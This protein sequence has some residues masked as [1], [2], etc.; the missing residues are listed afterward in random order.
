MTV[1][2]TSFDYTKD[3]ARALHGLRSKYEERRDH[4]FRLKNHV[5]RMLTR[6]LADEGL[7]EQVHVSGRVKEL[8][9]FRRKVKDRYDRLTHGILKRERVRKKTH[10]VK[11]EIDEL[12]ATR[13]RLLKEPFAFIGDL[14]GIRC[15]C[16]FSSAFDQHSMLRSVILRTFDEAKLNDVT[17]VPFAEDKSTKSGY[18]GVHYDLKL[19]YADDKD[20]K[21][22]RFEL[23]IRS[24]CQ[25]VWSEVSHT[26]AYKEETD[27]D[28]VK[29]RAIAS[30]LNAIQRDLDRLESA[31]TRRFDETVR[32][33]IDNGK[34]RAFF[35]SPISQRALRI[36]ALHAFKGFDPPLHR[37]TVQFSPLWLSHL[38][39]S[40]KHAG[41]EIVEDLLPI[42]KE[43]KKHMSAF[44]QELHEAGSTFKENDGTDLITKTLLFGDA[45]IGKGMLAQTY[46][47]LEQT[48]AY[49]ERRIRVP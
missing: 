31:A 32:D 4:Y 12:R 46:P 47:L 2:V 25:H 27:L 30:R 22:A 40:L 9:S 23:Q 49:I 36:L 16:T 34:T 28:Q 20:L 41:Y 7:T 17:A 42:V 35:R 3:Y 45:E 6:Q 44:R 13:S 21:E 29:L 24:L 39:D 19:R 14:V 1:D 11:W 38:A 15:L 33:V 10:A 43:G 26:L 37:G 48:R 8:D 5:V 18:K